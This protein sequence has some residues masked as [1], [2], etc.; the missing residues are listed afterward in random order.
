MNTI[1]IKKE[2]DKLNELKNKLKEYEDYYAFLSKSIEKKEGEITDQMVDEAISVLD[3]I[4][5]LKFKI[6][7]NENI[8]S[9]KTGKYASEVEVSCGNTHAFNPRRG[10]GSS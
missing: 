9:G 3:K 4:N 1:S 5:K 7:F 8:R 2:N 6:E 10:Y